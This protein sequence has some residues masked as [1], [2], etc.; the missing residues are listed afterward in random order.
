[1]RAAQGF[2]HSR[3]GIT[4]YLFSRRSGR[5]LP[6]ASAGWHGR[7]AERR[8][9][10]APRPSA[11]FRDS[12]ATENSMRRHTRRGL[13]LW[14][15]EEPTGWCLW[16][17]FGHVPL[18][19]SSLSVVSRGRTLRR[20]AT[21]TYRETWSGTIGTGRCCFGD[22]DSDEPGTSRCPWLPCARLLETGQIYAQ[23]E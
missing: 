21:L 5:S 22:D 19:A 12:N 23:Q 17:P 15:S 16:P 3:P 18:L 6:S 2:V 14:L 1:M 13:V 4:E 10:S 7:T 20:C 8:P 9:K 11:F